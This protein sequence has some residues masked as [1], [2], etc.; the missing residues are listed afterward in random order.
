MMRLAPMA[1][2]VSLIN[3]Y[4]KEDVK[5]LEELT[6]GENNM[7]HSNS[8]CINGSNLY[9]EVIKAM[10]LRESHEEIMGTLE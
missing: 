7:T 2:F 8:V 3:K 9:L 10:I 1:C 6:K 5:D 4:C